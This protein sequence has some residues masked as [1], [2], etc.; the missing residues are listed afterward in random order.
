MEVDRVLSVM[1]ILNTVSSIV[2][3][4]VSR[5][6]LGPRSSEDQPRRSAELAKSKTVETPGA[7]ENRTEPEIRITNYASTVFNPYQVSQLSP[8]A[9]PTVRCGYETRERRTTSVLCTRSSNWDV[10]QG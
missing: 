4:T 2:F 10:G 3:V 6:E 5:A 7:A 1:C 9:L 8:P